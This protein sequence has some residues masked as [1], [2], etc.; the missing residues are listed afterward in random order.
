LSSAFQKN[1]IPG[2][3]PGLDGF[4]GNADVSLNLDAWSETDGLY[5][6]A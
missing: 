1:S 6:P 4:V 2:Q 3:V 5:L